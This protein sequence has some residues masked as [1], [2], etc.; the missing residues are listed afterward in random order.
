MFT[1]TWRRPKQTHYGQ[2]VEL[3]ITPATTT[4]VP[5][6]YKQVHFAKF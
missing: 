3:D 2:S 5:T 1:A 6:M 4:I